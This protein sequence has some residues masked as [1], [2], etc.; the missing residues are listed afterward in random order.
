M[1]PSSILI[2]EYNN[3]W[4]EKLH[5]KAELKK[6]QAYLN[7]L[8]PT[9]SVA[10]AVGAG[11]LG[12]AGPGLLSEAASVPF[13]DFLALL[14]FPL[15]AV[16]PLVAVFMTT[17]LYNVHVISRHIANLERRISAADGA[18]LI[19]ESR[20][21]PVAYYGKASPNPVKIRNPI[22]LGAYVTASLAI[23]VYLGCLFYGFVFLLKG[24]DSCAPKVIAESVFLG[25]MLPLL[26]FAIRIV[27]MNREYTRPNS[28][29]ERAIDAVHEQVE[30]PTEAS[31]TSRTRSSTR[32]RRQVPPA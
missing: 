9:G 24:F 21:V 2:S 28:D 23:V 17:E 6:F 15:V 18:S 5:H 29:L 19:W 20:V 7:Y 1:N 3:L 22:E 32:S 25:T 16:L 27:L 10:L 13:L 12:E 26:G 11:K 14:V 4:Q 31:R 30:K 8:I